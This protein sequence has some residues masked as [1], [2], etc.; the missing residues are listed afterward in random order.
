MKIE[1]FFSFPNH[2]TFLMPPIAKIFSKY[3]T[4][5][6]WAD[7]FCGC[8]SP[9]KHTNDLNPDIPA[10]SHIDA[11]EFLKGFS[12]NS[13]DGVLYDRPYSSYQANQMYEGIGADMAHN[14]TWLTNIRKEI[15]RTI[16]PGGLCLTFCWNTQGIGTKN[17]FEIEHIYIINHGDFRN[18][19]LVT[20]ER[21]IQETL[22]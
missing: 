10:G 11:L 16:K 19:T 2:H 1:R 14:N 12:D 20:V 17:G 22:E 15:A 18:D 13:L 8:N 5:G 7:P 3:Y 9:A 21:K 4:A 6:E